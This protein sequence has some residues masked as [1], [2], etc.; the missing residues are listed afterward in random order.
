MISLEGKRVLLCED[1][2]LNA[3]ITIKVLEHAGASVVRARNGR[4]GLK[5]FLESVVGGFDAILMDISMPVMNGLET[6]EAIRALPREDAVKIPI[7]A[8]TAK[9]NEDDR[10]ESLASGMD[11]HLTKPVDPKELYNVMERLIQKT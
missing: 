1:H 10:E 4:E 8:M 11:T 2:T 5:L 7:I 9:Y 6:T 3:S